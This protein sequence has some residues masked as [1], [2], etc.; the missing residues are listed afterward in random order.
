MIRTAMIDPVGLFILA[1]LSRIYQLLIVAPPTS[2]QINGT[3]S[4]LGILL[5]MTA[6]YLFIL[7][8]YCLL[9]RHRGVG[10]V[11]C[12]YL[13]AGKAGGSIYTALLGLFSLLMLVKTVS[14]FTIFINET[15][16]QESSGIMILLLFLAM[17]IFAVH[18]GI[19]PIS[20]ISIFIVALL[21]AALAVLSF[22]L[23]SQFEMGNLY[24]P[25]YDGWKPVLHS[26]FV[27][28]SNNIEIL[29]IAVLVPYVKGDCTWSFH[30][31]VWLVL[32]GLEFI[33]FVATA[34]MG[35]YA[36][37]Q[38][39]PFF[40]MT[41]TAG[42]SLFQVLDSVYMVVWIL[43]A[44][45]RGALWL[46]VGKYC[47][48]KLVRQP[49]RKRMPVIC[50]IVSG[51]AALVI[52]AK[53]EYFERLSAIWYVAIPMAILGF[54]IPLILLLLSFLRKR[55]ENPVLDTQVVDSGEEDGE[56]Q[57]QIEAEGEVKNDG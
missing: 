11:D 37:T 29:A 1:F 48:G 14:G 31:Y 35:D 7:P 28:L 18:L 43:T 16:Y 34:A 3:A 53:G 38:R 42:F 51:T 21:I 6:C 26:A 10:L 47:L 25:L 36:S 52:S 15:V 49:V 17:V 4:M 12:G 57:S 8:L 23:V 32:V 33:V 20:R 22:S 56:G 40:S 24:S 41:R 2:Q 50:G 46:F 27:T 55:R 5:G 45:V 44:F 54:L 9:R 19:E 13:L 39:Y 30:R